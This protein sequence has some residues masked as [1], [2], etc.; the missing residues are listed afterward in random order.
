MRTGRGSDDPLVSSGLDR[1]YGLETGN[2][3]MTRCPITV[4]GLQK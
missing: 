3:V 4:Y 1:K 2:G